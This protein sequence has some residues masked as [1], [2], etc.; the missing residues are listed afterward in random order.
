MAEILDDRRQ[1]PRFSAA[2]SYCVPGAEPAIR[3]HVL[4]LSLNGALL[5]QSGCTAGFSPGQRLTIRL[6]LPDEDGFDVE[7]LIQHVADSRAGVE[8][9]DISPEHFTVLAGLVERRK[10][11]A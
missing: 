3:G 2:G 7:V 9:Y 1:E 5:E 8:F 10:T 4:D 11:L 6:E